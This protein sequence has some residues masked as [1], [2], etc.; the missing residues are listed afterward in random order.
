MSPLPGQRLRTRYLTVLALRWIPLG[1]LMPIFVVLMLEQGLG[2]G[3]VGLALACQSLAAMAAEIPSGMAADRWGQR[4]LLLIGSAVRVMALTLLLSADTLTLFAIAWTLEGFSRAMDSG[5][6]DSWY[7][8]AQ[9]A[10]RDHDEVARTFALGGTVI[11]L[12]IAGG[13]GATAAIGA[14]SLGPHSGVAAPVFVALVVQS[15]HLILTAV[16]VQQPS[17]DPSRSARE[18]VQ[19]R[20]SGPRLRSVLVP[21]LTLLFAAEMVWGFGMTSVEILW[22]PVLVGVAAD[23][24]TSD[25][26]TLL[27][28]VGLLGWCASAAGAA[29]LVL[30]GVRAMDRWLVALSTRGLQALIVCAF[31]LLEPKPW[32]VISYVLIYLMHGASNPAHLAL[33]HEQASD[34]TRSTAASVNSFAA[35]VGGT[36]G[37]LVLPAVAAF[38]SLTTALLLGA[39]LIGM[40]AAGY[41][42]HLSD[43]WRQRVDHELFSQD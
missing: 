32:L 43:A 42:P 9:P 35:Q 33:L 4:R 41:I 11:G 1:L 2:L 18:G 22:Q 20:R 16:A 26:V 40:S 6:L 37:A 14:L 19:V 25:D 3:A 28:A 36:A 10:D 23:A 17:I 34:A 39:A 21:G 12:S 8:N 7:V 15:A 29:V 5:A 38:G 31:A 24:V 13:S 30:P 27:G